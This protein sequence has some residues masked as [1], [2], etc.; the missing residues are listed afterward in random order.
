MKK[1]E[2]QYSLDELR[3]MYIDQNLSGKEIASKYN[4]PIY[5]VEKDLKNNKIYKSK[6]LISKGRRKKVDKDELY[7][8]YIVENHST[9]ETAK[10]F[11]VDE[12][13]IRNRLR[14]FGIKKSIDLQVQCSKNNQIKK[15]GNLFTRSE[16]YKE[17]VVEKM[18]R[19]GKNTCIKK[20]G[21]PNW[22]M[23]EEGS[24][25]RK[26][27]YIYNNIKFDSSWELAL[28]IYAID[29]N[30]NI[31][32]EP[33]KFEYYINDSVHYYIPDFLYKNNYIEIKGTHLIKEG[34]LQ[35][36]F[37]KQ[38][39]KDLAK[40]NCIEQNGVIIMSYD[41]I[42]EKLSYINKTYGKNYLKKFKVIN[43]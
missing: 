3:H 13:T 33:I 15:Y 2:R 27:K 1:L 12:R 39:Y 8:F 24:K 18:I 40:Q 11:N 34:K 17:N 36:V 25:A 29:H 26:A 43:K 42:Q 30:E 38:T 41:E 37:K 10:F 4:I 35:N 14:E 22:G 9:E 6:D 32:R 5:C 19:K 16:Y 7:N 21:V 20:Y 31:V 23:T 28:Y